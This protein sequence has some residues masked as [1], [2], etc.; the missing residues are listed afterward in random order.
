MLDASYGEVFLCGHQSPRSHP[1]ELL[2]N[3]P[4]LRIWFDTSVCL[5]GGSYHNPEARGQSPTLPGTWYWCNEHVSGGEGIMVFG[6]QRDGQKCQYVRY[7]FLIFY[8]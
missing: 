4:N 3:W 1:S 7:R 2:L 5:L 6:Q 8:L